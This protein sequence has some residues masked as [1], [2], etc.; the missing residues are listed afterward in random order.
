[1]DDIFHLHL[2]EGERIRGSVQLYTITTYNKQYSIVTFVTIS[3]SINRMIKRFSPSKTVRRQSIILI[4]TK[5]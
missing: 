5:T 1:M 4:T 2:H 3:I